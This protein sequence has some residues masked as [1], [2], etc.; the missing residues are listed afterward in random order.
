[1]TALSR[2][3]ISLHDA[4]FRL[5]ERLVFENT[6]WNF[7]K[8][9]QWAVGGP[10]GCGKSLFGEAIAGRLPLVHGRLD[11]HFRAPAGLAPEQ[12]IEYVAFA[13][14]KNQVRDAIAQSRWHSAEDHT[15]LRVRDFLAFEQVM[16]INP[17]EVAP[18]P[19]RV[20]QQ[21]ERR[22][23]QA[24]SWL[25]LKS[26]LDRRILALSNGE[27]QRVQL[28]RALCRPVRLLVL[29]E[30]MTG[31]DQAHRKQFAKVLDRLMAGTL[32]VL[33]L[34][35]RPEEMP[36]RISHVLELKECQVE[37]ASGR[38]EF[39]RRLTPTRVR[40]G[41]SPRQGL[42]ALP[43]SPVTSLLRGAPLIELRQVTVRYGR[44]VIFEN[45]SWTVQEGESWILVGPNG[46]GKTAL[47]SLISGDHPQA[48]ANDIRVFGRR[49][50]PGESI[51]E[52]KRQIGWVSP[53]QQ[54]HFP[55]T[56][57][58]LATVES[59]F[60]ESVALFEPV[61]SAQRRQARQW[62]ER[63]QLE[64]FANEPFFSLSTGWQRVVL[65]ARALVGK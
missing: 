22:R 11:Y 28:A 17:F 12:A 7:S 58:C 64:G 29:D 1:M 56:G 57:S 31:L 34:T 18:I 19:R 8:G 33:L 54:V 62:L 53:E 38:R 40:R 21:F 65:L 43:A 48:F 59:G 27:T 32:R 39:E 9:Q 37:R 5:G 25:D 24:I 41:R 26:L 10:N 63:F 51:W 14:R 4:S 45:L 52:I 55:Q 13:S 3:F 30:P 46:S 35:D 23:R 16:E 61:T 2:P 60:H 20:R 6:S 47:L 49:R 42:K 15:G 36:R 50:G 44:S